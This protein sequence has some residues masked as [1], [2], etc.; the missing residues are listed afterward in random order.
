MK[1]YILYLQTIKKPYKMTVSELDTRIKTIISLLKLFPGAPDNGKIFSV[2][3]HKHLFLSSMPQAWQDKFQTSG[4]T[5]MNT[6]TWPGLIRYFAEC[7]KQSLRDESAKRSSRYNK[8]SS[9]SKRGGGPRWSDNKKAKKYHGPYQ[10]G[11]GQYAR[12]DCPFHPKE[13]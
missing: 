11:K 10:V 13:L 7:R 12:N 5:L 6:T 8:G 1:T 9:G 3:T 4:K 2:Q